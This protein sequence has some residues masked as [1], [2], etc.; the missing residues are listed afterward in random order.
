MRVA[1]I[2][3]GIAGLSAAHA[4]LRRGAD[5]VVFEA[6]L[7]AGG[8]VGSRNERGWLT[9]DGPHFIAR[10]LE[11]LLETAGLGGEVVEPRGSTARFV[12]LRGRVLR[13][14]S[15]RFLA[16]AGAARAALEPLFTGPVRDE[17]TLRELLVARF[18]GRAGS[19]AAELMASGVYAGDPDHLSARDAF[20]SLAENGSILL[21]ALRGKRNRLWSLRRGL[22]SL[23]ELLAAKLGARLRLGAPVQGLAPAQGGWDVGPERFEAAVLAMPAAGAADLAREFSPPLAGALLLLRAAPVALVHLGFPRNGL[24]GGFGMLDADGTLHAVG[25]IFPSS[26]LPGRAPQGRTLLS[27]ICGGARHPERAALPDEELIKS[28]CA[29]LRRT[30]G[31]RND[32]EYVRIVRHPVGIPQYA[33]GHRDRVRAARELLPAR[34]ELA[35]AAYDGVSVPDAAR[36]GEAAAERLLA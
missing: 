22:G 16:A 26:M 1:V 36:S 3:G 5:P 24:P 2:G 8:K 23:P 19:L 20:P 11:G 33:P 12:H 34:L 18:G 15:L 21:R 31:V 35:G 7:R 17:A 27:A 4:L 9:E 32:P 29:D 10:P 30:L 25:T 28:V 13:A 6:A 14:P